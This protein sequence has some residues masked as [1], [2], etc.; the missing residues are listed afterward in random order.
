M[1]LALVRK[2]AIEDTYN[3]VLTVT[4]DLV[5]EGG[6]SAAQMST[7]ASRAGLAIGS[8]YRYFDTKVDLCVQILSEVSEREAA[9]VRGILTSEGDVSSRL[10]DAIA[11]FVRRAFRKP[12][13][14]YALI[15]EPCEPALDEARLRY[16]KNLAEVFADAIREG[17]AS[18]EF[19]STPADLLSTCVI[20]AM[21]EPLIQPLA[22]ERVLSRDELKALANDIANL[23]MRMVCVNERR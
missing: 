15:A 2:Q 16:R 13:L 3:R 14:A 21:M 11:V 7:I 18:G 1:A 8:L 19:V 5:A 17:A 12:R 10:H 6:W 4:R 9:I 20:G 22:R 23:C